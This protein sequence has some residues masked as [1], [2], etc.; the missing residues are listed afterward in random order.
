MKRMTKNVEGFTLIEL[1]IVV[2][3]IGILAAIAI[4]S[5]QG[6][7]MK[8][9]VN[10]A[11]GELAAY[12]SPVEESLARG[13]AVSNNDIGYVSSSL[14]TGVMATD[15]AV[16]NADGSGH[17]EVTM[18]GNAHRDLAGL[19]IRFQ[20]SVSGDWQCIIDSSGASAWRDAY[21]PA[22]CAVI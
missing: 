6:H 12:K 18:G 22:S 5:Y 21:S 16:I 2:A 1:M 9:Q 14:T 10:R 19:V 17:L 8:T 7:V 13:G 11:L 20:R 15:I 4:P 3:V